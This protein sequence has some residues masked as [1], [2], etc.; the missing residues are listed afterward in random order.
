MLEQAGA[1]QQQEDEEQSIDDEG[2]DD[3][4]TKSSSTN[5]NSKPS[6]EAELHITQ[7]NKKTAISK[8]EDEPINVKHSLLGT[9]K[10]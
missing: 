5:F 6:K 4:D 1:L 8:K 7:T 2:G 9:I 3:E 10:Q